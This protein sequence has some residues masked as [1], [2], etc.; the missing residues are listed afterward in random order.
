MGR[1][2][3]DV[4]SYFLCE[5]AAKRKVAI[6]GSRGRSQ[7]PAQTELQAGSSR[8]VRT[9]TGKSFLLGERFTGRSSW[10]ALVKAVC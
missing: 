8:T 1:S 4:I 3:G 9:D 2:L 10:L 5:Q 6:V 7:L